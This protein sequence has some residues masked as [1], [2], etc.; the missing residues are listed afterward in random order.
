[1]K[2]LKS[3]MAS[4]V[5]IL[6]D[7]TENDDKLINMLREEINRLKSGKSKNAVGTKPKK[8]ESEDSNEVIY[9]L[10]NDNAK[11]KS[12]IIVLKAE[13]NKKEAKINEL[14]KN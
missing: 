13:V 10:K 7:K 12:D 11:L 9:N 8:N 1:M 14:M 3:L 5:K 2:E 4:K 6:L